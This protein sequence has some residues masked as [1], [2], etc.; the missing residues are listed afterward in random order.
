MAG[1]AGPRRRRNSPFGKNVGVEVWVGLASCC[2]AVGLV[3]DD[4]LREMGWAMIC[5]SRGDQV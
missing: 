5:Q 3:G 2:D 4:M 1:L